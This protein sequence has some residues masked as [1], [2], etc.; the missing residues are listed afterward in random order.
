[1]SRTERWGDLN[2]RLISAAVM[3]AIGL[4]EVW[5]GGAPFMVAVWVL[6]G[7]MIWELS[8]MLGGRAWAPGMGVIAAVALGLAWILPVWLALPGLI[9]VACFGAWQIA[10]RR[11][12][13][14]FFAGATLL[15]CHAAVLLRIEA[16]MGWL[17]WVVCVVVATDVAGYMAGRALGG[18]KF[19]PAISPKKTWSG[20]VAGWMAAAVTGLIFGYALGVGAQLMVLS[21]PLSLAGQAGD[22]WESWI[23]RRVGVKDSSNLIPGHGGVLDRF[24]AMLGATLLTGVL[25]LFGLLP[26]LSLGLS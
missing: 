26:G 21:I 6:G 8:R 7:A 19:W 5:L 24:D 9:A 23:K 16:G 12:L 3:I 14:G 15:A 13:F 25:W 2:V 1:M 22:V 17:L 11:I 4:V 10:S 18:P 20:T